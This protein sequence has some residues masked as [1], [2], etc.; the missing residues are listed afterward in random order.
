MY[1]VTPMAYR[2]N[3]HEKTQSEFGGFDRRAAA[4]DG[5]LAVSINMSAARYPALT[6]RPRRGVHAAVAKPNGLFCR[7]CVAWVDGTRLIVDGADVAAVTDSRKIMAGIQKK[8]CIWPDKV[9]YDR[10]TGELQQMGASWEGTAT[11]KDGTYAGEPAA[12]N[13]IEAK[14]DLR[15]IF[16]AGDGVAVAVV[17][18]EYVHEAEGAFV[19]QEVEYDSTDDETEL[20]FL[21]DTWLKHMPP[22]YETDTAADDG[23]L[24]PFPNPGMKTTVRIQRRAPELEGVFEHHNRLW[25]W[26]GGTICCSKLGDPTNWEVFSGDAA[27]SWELETGTPGDI[28]GGIS[29]GGRPVF[30]KEHRIIRLYGDY[31]GQFSTSETESLGVEAGSGGSLAIAG[32]TLYYLSPQGV[33]A[34]GGGYPY[35][36]GENFGE[37]RYRNAVAGSDGVRYYISAQNEQGVYDVFCFDTRHRVWHEEDGMA[38]LGLGW[39]GELYALE[40]RG[41]VFILGERRV[42]SPGEEGIAT[43]VEFADFTEGTTRKKGVSRLVLRLE[44]DEDT[45]LD[46][47][48]RYDSRGDWELLRR[49]TGEMVKG[50]EEIVIPLRRCDHYRIRLEGSGL[51]GCGWTLHSLTRERRV[52]SNRK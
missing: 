26:H 4:G 25:G 20:R 27:D 1:G 14:V 12:A 50:Q 43:T 48:I 46:I 36:V 34:Y 35:P 40:E 42:E 17:A 38:F 5:A 37:D 30:F 28:T 44:M 15:E 2:G 49:L 39:H 7:D 19:I 8:L 9:I 16:R 24:S 21:E 33:M 6:V 52:G 29:Y 18:D 10:E 31:P 23:E 13:T 11:F 51:G 22:G 32:D 41:Q 45:T 47:K 3:Y